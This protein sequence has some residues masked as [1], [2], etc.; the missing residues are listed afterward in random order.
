MV[1]LNLTTQALKSIGGNYGLRRGMY[2]Y[3]IRTIAEID[4]YQLS[5]SSPHTIFSHFFFVS[6]LPQL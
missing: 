1:W 5:P 4:I 2:P 6:I 3:M